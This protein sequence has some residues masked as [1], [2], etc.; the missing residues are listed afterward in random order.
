MLFASFTHAKTEK[1]SIGLSLNETESKAVPVQ[2]RQKWCPIKVAFLAKLSQSFGANLF[3]R[4][5]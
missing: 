2:D 4:L 1:H 3:V 5:L